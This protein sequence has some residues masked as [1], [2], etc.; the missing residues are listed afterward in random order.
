MF[1]NLKIIDGVIQAG[2]IIEVFVARGKSKDR[3]PL[4]NA[5][6]DGELDEEMDALRARVTK[7]VT[8]YV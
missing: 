1:H 8:E 5:L 7:S 4:Y 3:V 2:T 6:S